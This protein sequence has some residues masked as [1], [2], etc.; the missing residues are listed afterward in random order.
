MDCKNYLK[1]F[2]LIMI[3]ILTLKAV[4]AAENEDNLTFN[5]GI[6]EKYTSR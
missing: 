5:D 4:S 6:T 1:I 2:I 3:C